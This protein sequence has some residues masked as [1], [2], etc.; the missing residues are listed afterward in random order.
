M[1][2]IIHTA[3]AP[4]AI[5]P[6]SQAVFAG[7]LLFISGQL[8][9]DPAT[10][11][12]AGSTVEEQTRRAFENIKAILTAASLDFSNVVKTTVLLK[13]IGDF[14]AVNTIYGS[15]FSGD[16]PARAAYEVANLPK[17]GL[18]EIEVIACKG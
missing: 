10:G 11:E 17:G 15:Y 16:F 14:A 12:F 1:K 9:L 8:G 3:D 6:Y 4:A 5:G 7:D 18:I 13:S 2:K